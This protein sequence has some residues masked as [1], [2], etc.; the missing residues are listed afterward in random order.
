MQHRT[1]SSA[2]AGALHAGRRTRPQRT[3]RASAALTTAGALLLTGCAGSGD[4]VGGIETADG[5][6]LQNAEEV[7]AEATDAWSATLPTENVETS[8]ETRCF[9]VV[10]EDEAITEEIAC[11]GVRTPADED[12]HVWSVGSFEVR[13]NSDE[14]MEAHLPEAWVEQ[15]QR[16][17]ER[18]GATVVDADGEPAPEEIDALAAPP[19]PQAPEEILVS[20][21]ALPTDLVQPSDEVVSPGEGGRV[22]TPA[23][24]LEIISVAMPETIPVSTDSAEGAAPAEQ[25]SE[26]SEISLSP[27]GEPHGPADEEVFVV[28]EYEFTPEESLDGEERTAALAINGG[29]VQRT[30]ADLGETRGYTGPTEETGR[31]LVSVASEDPHLVISSAGVDQRIDLP[32]GERTESSVASAYYRDV[33]RQDVNHEFDVEDQ[34]VVIDDDE[35]TVSLYQ[36]LQS[37]QLTAFTESGG[38]DG[39]TEEGRA[40]LLLEFDSRME[41]QD[42]SVDVLEY[43]STTTVTDGSGEEHTAERTLPE[44]W[45]SSGYRIAVSVPADAEEFTVAQAIEGRIED[46]DTPPLPLNFSVPALEVAFPQEEGDAPDEAEETDQAGAEEQDDSGES[47]PSDEATDEGN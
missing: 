17:V 21:S 14:E 6:T 13:Q 23:G 22:I 24:T 1:G 42:A 30:L 45:Y 38:G 18:P 20:G 26:G 2:S 25:L 44:H 12:G 15:L 10:G 29:G 11:G 5:E 33:T 8:E 3:R 27:D 16:G 32:E 47:D 41:V 40:W 9:F 7:L 34:T 35:H 46:W 37:A 39:W 19:M 4:G 31:M 36:N 28:L 43:N